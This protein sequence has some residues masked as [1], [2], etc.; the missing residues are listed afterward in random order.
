MVLGW[1]IRKYFH[2]KLDMELSVE[3]LFLS[4]FW[5]SFLL[6]MSTYVFYPICC[7]LGARIRPV[8][9]HKDKYLPFVSIIIA[10]YNEERH[11]ERKLINTLALDYPAEKIEIIVGSDGSTDG[12]VAI[13]Q[14]FSNQGVTVFDFPKNRGKT[15]VQNACV[16]EAKGEILVFTDAA[17]FLGSN[18]LKKIMANFADPRVGCVAGKVRY[19]DTDQNITT[20]GQGIYW[21]YEQKIKAAESKLGSLIGVDGPLYAMRKEYYVPLEA[22]IISDLISPLLVLFQK[23]LVVLEPEAIVDEDPCS[24]TQQELNTRRRIALRGLVGLFQFRELLNP[25]KNGPA[26][27]QIIFHKLIRWLVGPLI[28]FNFMSCLALSGRQFFD[29]IL[30]GY[31]SFFIMVGFGWVLSRFE[32]N[33]S[34]VTIP[35]YFTLVNLAAT[36]GIIDFLRKK[37]AITWKPVRH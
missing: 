31:S 14:K 33:S 25:F 20:E 35:Y 7:F 26:A 22:N 28:L 16:E 2:G 29:V 18:A 19:V 12:T 37:E 10:A 11:I 30:F 3:G 36:L 5:T 23:K 34:F 17:S 27:F 32:V 4:I 21:Q 15:M 6:C 1:L 13:A 8:R 24:K 9:I